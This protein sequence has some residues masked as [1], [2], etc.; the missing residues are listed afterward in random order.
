MAD[1]KKTRRMIAKYII[2]DNGSTLF[3][4]QDKDQTERT[5]NFD[6]F[7]DNVKATAQQY[8]IGK[9]LKDSYSETDGPDAAV[10]QFDE[11]Y[12][13]LLAGTW[14]VKR[15]G[16]G[17]VTGKR[18]RA[19]FNLAAGAPKWADKF[20]GLAKDEITQENVSE[21]YDTQDDDLQK[22]INGSKEVRLELA[23]MATADADTAETSIM[24]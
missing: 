5:V 16:G 10:A 19:L 24:G 6:L 20:M 7:P 3:Q 21:W 17:P 14:N 11:A 4:F 15:A 23:R 8:G 2:Q 13:A 12:N 9:K 22:S 18:K 1:A